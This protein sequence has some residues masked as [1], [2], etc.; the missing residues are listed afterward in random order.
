MSGLGD[1]IVLFAVLV[2]APLIFAIIMGAG[3]WG[4]LK[5]SGRSPKIGVLEVGL[6]LAALAPGIAFILFAHNRQFG[7]WLIIS[8]GASISALFGAGAVV[9]WL[10]A[11]SRDRPPGGSV[12]VGRMLGGAGVGVFPIFLLLSL[13]PSLV[14]GRITLNETAAIDALNTYASAQVHFH[15]N[16]HYGIGKQVHAN[17]RDG[18][19]F[20]DLHEIGGPG[21]G[22][23]VLNL[24]DRDLAEA[25]SP[26]R[27]MRGYWF[28]DIT[29]DANG[30]YD[31]SKQFGL[32]A[33][34][35]EYRRSGRRTFIIDV[36]G[37]VYQ[38][39]IEGDSLTTWPDLEE[40]GWI[41]LGGE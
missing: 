38:S 34:P 36:R 2:V 18:T 4:K 22:S 39:I 9:G 26:E 28:V 23:K 25:T 13:I 3:R 19:G 33:V 40:E 11:N 30:P 7:I 21:P 24:I 16:D 12:T 15:R 27:A 29:G 35:A 5:E 8:T 10:C 37:K 32:C 41:P 14:P 1:M 20:P 31:H 17:P 6:F